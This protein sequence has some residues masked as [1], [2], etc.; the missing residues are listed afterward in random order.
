M[1]ANEITEKILAKSG[2]FSTEEMKFARVYLRLPTAGGK[3]SSTRKWYNDLSGR[4]FQE[5]SESVSEKIKQLLLGT[6]G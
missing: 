1:N 5:L 2:L 3:N 4:K 6:E